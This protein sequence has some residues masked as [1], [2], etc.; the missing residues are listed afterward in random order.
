MVATDEYSSKFDYSRD[1]DE[2]EFTNAICS[3]GGQSIVVGSYDRLC[4]ESV[5]NNVVPDSFFRA[6]MMITCRAVVPA[7][8]V[9]KSLA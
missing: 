8:A 3:P 4:T 5:C 1:D 7:H 2:H 9:V 6:K